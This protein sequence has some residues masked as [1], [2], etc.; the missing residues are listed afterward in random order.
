MCD[1]IVLSAVC[2]RAYVLSEERVTMLAAWKGPELIEVASRF[3]K[4][5]RISR[6]KNAQ[7]TS[8]FPTSH[9]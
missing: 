2:V 8:V 4:D 7:A 6:R 1:V 3:R 5:K 9:L